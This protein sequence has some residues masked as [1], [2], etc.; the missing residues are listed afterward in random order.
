MIVQSII[1]SVKCSVQVNK[2]DYGDI[3]PIFTY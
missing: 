3:L 1:G 2:E